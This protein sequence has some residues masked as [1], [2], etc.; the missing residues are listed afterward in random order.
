VRAVYPLIL[1]ISELNFSHI[2]THEHWT[3]R[4]CAETGL[5]D[6]YEDRRVFLRR[7]VDGGRPTHCADRRPGDGLFDHC[8]CKVRCRCFTSLLVCFVLLIVM[9]SSACEVTSLLFCFVLLIVMV[10]SACEVTSL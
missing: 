7:A 6:G 2:Y 10:S 9:V 1:S 4:F 8:K 5:N 3:R